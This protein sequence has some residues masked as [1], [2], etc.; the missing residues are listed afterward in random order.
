MARKPIPPEVKR[1][2]NLRDRQQRKRRER[3]WP[4]A[5]HLADQQLALGPETSAPKAEDGSEPQTR[6]QAA[7]SDRW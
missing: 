5:E 6:P 7:A 3:G 1:A 4:S 2:R